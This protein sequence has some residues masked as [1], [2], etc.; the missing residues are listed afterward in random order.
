MKNFLD[1]KSFKGLK[2]L[3]GLEVLITIAMLGVIY[4]NDVTVSYW[5]PWAFMIAIFIWNLSSMI[6][7]KYFNIGTLVVTGYFQYLC[8]CFVLHMMPLT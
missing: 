7:N 4:I 2:V 3:M 5:N 6:D 8:W 1:L